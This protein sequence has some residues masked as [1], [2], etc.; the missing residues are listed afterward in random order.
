MPNEGETVIDSWLDENGICHF[1]GPE[2]MIP[3]GAY[4]ANGETDILELV[5]GI[6]YN[7]PGPGFAVY[8]WD[9]NQEAP[10]PKEVL[11]R[12]IGVKM[13]VETIKF[14]NDENNGRGILLAEAAG[15]ITQNGLTPDEWIAKYGNNGAAAL[16]RARLFWWTRGGGVHVQTSPGRKYGVETHPVAGAGQ[17]RMNPKP[18]APKGVVVGNA[19]KGGK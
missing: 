3:T 19:A 10:I 5:I 4:M 12:V 13:D 14:L 9:K 6:V 15:D 16:A 7:K 1:T 8:D 11:D 2:T 17:V 18:G